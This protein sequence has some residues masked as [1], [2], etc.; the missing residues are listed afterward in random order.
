MKETREHK[1][2]REIYQ[3]LRHEEYDIIT[4]VKIMREL[5]KMMGQAIDE[6]EAKTTNEAN[7]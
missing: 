6:L 2:A 7:K 1:A 3:W 4:A 5:A